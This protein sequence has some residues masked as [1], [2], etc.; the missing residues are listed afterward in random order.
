MANDNL[1]QALQTAGVQPD[2]LAEIVQVDHRTVRRWLSGQ[3]PYRRHRA[4]IAS[5]LNTSEHELWPD[6]PDPAP[7]ATDHRAAAAADDAIVG[8]ARA[9]DL[10]APT[11]EQLIRDARERIELLDVTLHRLLNRPGLPELLADKAHRGCRVRILVTEPGAYLTPLL[12]TPGIEVRAVDGTDPQ[13]IHRIDDQILIGLSLI[14][15]IDPPPPLLHLRR[16]APDQL[17]DRL[18]AYYDYLWE[19]VGEPIETEQDIDAYQSDNDELKASDRT[20]DQSSQSD[21]AQPTRPSNEPAVERVRQWPR[22][23]T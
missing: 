16:H 18:T 17:F 10:N 6:L 15:E 19:H 3:V 4:K 23:R 8:Y 2:E 11:P 20:S 13:T 9:D 12:G 21:T 1:R 5:A 7:T 22:R 14:G